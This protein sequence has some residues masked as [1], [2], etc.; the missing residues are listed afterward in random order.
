MP[1]TGDGNS[2]FKM[3]FEEFDDKAVCIIQMPP[4][5][6]PLWRH[7]KNVR[8]FLQRCRSRGA[9]KLNSKGQIRYILEKFP[10]YK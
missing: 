9:E 4:S 7:D 5:R 8:I 6:V 2:E 10:N 3:K 1:K